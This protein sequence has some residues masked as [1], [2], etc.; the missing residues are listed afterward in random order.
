MSFSVYAVIACLNVTLQAKKKCIL[1][2]EQNEE[3]RTYT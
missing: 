1:K 3:K 2:K